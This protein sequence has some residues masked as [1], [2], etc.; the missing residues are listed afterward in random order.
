V[1][2]KFSKAVQ[3][4]TIVFTLKDPSSATVPATLSYNTSTRVAT[5]QPNALLAQNTTFTASVSGATDN[6]GN[7]MTPVSWTFTTGGCPCS[8]FPS[9]ATPATANVSDTNAVE[10]GMKFRSD[11]AGTI[12]AARFYKGSQN[13]GTHVAHLWS[14]TGQLLA[15]GTFSGE[16]ASG[17]QQVTFPTPV[18]ISANTTYVISYHTDV[19]FYSATGSY[20]AG[21]TA[22]SGPLHGLADG[23]D[24]GNGVYGYGA[25]AFPTSSFGSTNYWVDVVF[26]VP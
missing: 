5:L 14:G 20:F 18:Q 11:V 3:Q 25:S 1:T 9:T 7:V 22:N 6:F 10:V 17:W 16:S 13:T 24:G 2:A 19:G 4:S 15:T 21:F 23:T 12:T 8:V 26:T